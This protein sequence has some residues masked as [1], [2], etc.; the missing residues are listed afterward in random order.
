MNCKCIV[1]KVN[2][3]ILLQPA[4]R[5]N[6]TIKIWKINLNLL[7]IIKL[8]SIMSFREII[9]KSKCLTFNLENLFKN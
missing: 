2:K 3:P 1:L 4:D 6:N 9:F 5:L 8:L 7:C